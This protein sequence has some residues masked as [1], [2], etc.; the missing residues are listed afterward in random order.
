[1]INRT[2]V[3]AFVSVVAMS[4]F[5]SGRISGDQE[6][7]SIA[8]TARIIRINAKAKTMVV[9]SSEGSAVRVFPAFEV[10]GLIIPGGIAIAL[11][12]R[13][14]SFDDYTVVTTGDTTFQDG[15][16]PLRF[17]DFKNGEV[18]SIH[19]ERSGRILTASRVA[20]WG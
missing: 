6:R 12:A 17:E 20:K 7:V 13:A 15:V 14:G 10:P 9:R 5:G 11:P 3:T 16:D 4:V 2:I 18:I 8:T 1:V 19:G